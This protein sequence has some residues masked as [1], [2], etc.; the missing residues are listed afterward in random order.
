MVRQRKKSFKQKNDKWTRVSNACARIF[1]I[2]WSIEIEKAAS[3]A[4]EHIMP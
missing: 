2:E 3:Y 4:M 1:V